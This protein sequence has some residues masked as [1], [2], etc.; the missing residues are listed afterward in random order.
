MKKRIFFSYNGLLLFAATV[1]IFAGCSIILG[2]ENPVDPKAETYD[3]YRT[4]ESVEDVTA[5]SPAEDEEMLIPRFSASRIYGGAADLYGIQIS[6]TED[7]LS[8]LWENQAAEANTFQGPETGLT[9]SPL[10]YRVRAREAGG[11][12]GSYSNPVYFTGQ[13]G[14]LIFHLYI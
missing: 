4:V 9:E 2:F 3:G 14:L 7:F 13:P 10:Y 11:D 12:W 6:E 5:D 8:I 1:T